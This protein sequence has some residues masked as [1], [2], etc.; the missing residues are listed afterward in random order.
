M[1]TTV[2]ERYE[3]YHKTRNGELTTLLTYEHNNATYSVILEQSN[4]P[5]VYNLVYLNSNTQTRSVVG[6]IT[7]LPTHLNNKLKSGIHKIIKSQCSRYVIIKMSQSHLIHC[8]S[9][10]PVF[11]PKFEVFAFKLYE[12]TPVNTP[13]NTQFAGIAWFANQGPS[14][15]KV[16]Y[17]FTPSGNF[18]YC[19]YDSTLHKLETANGREVYKGQV[20]DTNF[21]Q[22]IPLDD[23]MICCQYMKGY[24]RETGDN[25]PPVWALA[26]EQKLYFKLGRVLASGIEWLDTL[27][28][29]ADDLWLLPVTYGQLFSYD[30]NINCILDRNTLYFT[31]ECRIS[32]AVLALPID[33]LANKFGQGYIVYQHPATD[34]DTLCPVLKYVHMDK[35][36]GVVMND[37][38]FQIV[39]LRLDSP[40]NEINNLDVLAAGH[41]FNLPHKEKWD[42]SAH[43]REIS[44]IDE[45]VIVNRVDSLFT[46]ITKTIKNI[47]MPGSDNID[48]QDEDPYNIIEVGGFTN[49]YMGRIHDPKQSKSE[50]TDIEFTPDLTC[51]LVC[52]SDSV[53]V[54]KAKLTYREVDEL[55]T[56]MDTRLADLGIDMPAEILTDIA[57]TVAV[58]EASLSVR[59]RHK[60][61]GAAELEAKLAERMRALNNDPE[62]KIEKQS[63]NDFMKPQS[64]RKEKLPTVGNIEY[65]TN[66]DVNYGTGSSSMHYGTLE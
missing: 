53:Y 10:S 12:Y 42:H 65:S 36:Y 41:H 13:I 8:Y 24:N 16:S 40:V 37:K 66:P 17:Y 5:A 4:D 57:C 56:N 21:K 11:E 15:S 2:G 27:E 48:N 22:L 58:P 32:W 39:N 38:N 49:E 51:V 23:T 33:M 64:V 18:L 52:Y 59:D 55:V 50:I 1:S 60:V 7:D 61:V 9:L 26:T 29:L 34:R 46:K 3:P 45:P 31:Y 43:V 62:I 25:N 20:G 30:T 54:Y 44:F 63:T 14:I 35:L 28:V 47:V 19:M 6:K